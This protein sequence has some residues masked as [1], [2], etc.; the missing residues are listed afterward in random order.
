MFGL[1]TDFRS[2]KN[3]TTTSFDRG[4][5]SGL[6]V[7]RWRNSLVAI[8]WLSQDWVPE[9]GAFFALVPE[10]A[11]L[12]R[13]SYPWERSRGA[14]VQRASCADHGACEQRNGN[15]WRRRKGRQDTARKITLWSG[16]RR[17]TRRAFIDLNRWR[18]IAT[19]TYQW[20][21]NRQHG[22]LLQ[23]CPDWVNCQIWRLRPTVWVLVE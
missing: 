9:A 11:S 1:Q 4:L 17:K 14:K 15:H 18:S 20:R 10:F 13:R 22:V 19:R 21:R 23:R 5:T 8:Q 7:K 6:A 3:D 12:D 16:R 2:Q